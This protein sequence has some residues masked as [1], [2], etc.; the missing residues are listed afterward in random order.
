ML[1]AP[2]KATDSSIVPEKKTIDKK[3]IV[4]YA[5]DSSL[6][7]KFALPFAAVGFGYAIVTRRSKILFVLIGASLG[8][9]TE[10]I[11]K[12]VQR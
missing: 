5:K 1:D 3:P 7:G 11:I 6:T 10:A 4:S 12:T 9:A 2:N 8:F